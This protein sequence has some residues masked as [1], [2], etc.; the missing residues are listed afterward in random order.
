[1][2][3][4]PESEKPESPDQYQYRSLPE[5]QFSDLIRA[6]SANPVKDLQQLMGW[7][8][9]NFLTGN[10]DGHAENLSLMYQGK[11]VRLAPL[12]D[13]M[14]TD[15]YE[16]LSKKLAMKIGGENRPDYADADGM[17]FNSN[18]DIDHY[19]GKKHSDIE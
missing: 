17:S 14:C 9:F 11:Q 13:M 15:I 19:C 7:V 10:M 18:G 16:D 1:L 4:L 8:F 3:I 12:Y 5:E 6:Y 2:S